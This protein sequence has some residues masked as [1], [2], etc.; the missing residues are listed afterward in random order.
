MLQSVLGALRLGYEVNL[1]VD[2][3]GSITRETHDVA[4]ERM[5][6]AGAVPTTWYSLA[7]EF[8]YDHTSPRAPILQQIMRENQPTMAKG[9]E[10]Y[11]AAKTPL[12][13]A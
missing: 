10:A 4:V 12:Q 1:I 2:A 13:V 9:V 11:A 7:G 5:V 6:Q 8:E 3:S